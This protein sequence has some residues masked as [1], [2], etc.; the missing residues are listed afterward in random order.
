MA[1][2]VVR[3]L[4]LSS[5]TFPPFRVD[6]TV[7]FGRELAA[8]GFGV[9]WILQ[10]ATPC[11]HAF[12]APW[13]GGSVWVGPTDRGESRLNRLRK[14][15]LG[16]LHDLSVMKRARPGCYDVVQV[17]DKV[18]AAFPALWAARRSGAAFIY[19]LSFPHPEAS[20]YL[21]RIGAAR[22]RLLYR[23]RGWVQ[24]RL[25]YRIILPRADHVFVQ[26][27]QMKRDL[28]SYGLDASK[29]TPVPMG[30]EMQDFAEVRSAPRTNADVAPTIGYLGTLAGERRID[31]LVRCLPLVLKHKP[32]A[33]LLLVGGGDRPADVEN[34]TAE[35][36]RLGVLD[37][38]E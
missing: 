26:S 23:I 36:R 38:L 18:L 29:M 11:E 15:W 4:V 20:S 22:Y 8:R 33:R 35:A 28:V 7:L 21:A 24:F 3:M 27:E 25:L 12:A 2:P 13:G 1:D 6:V 14:H 9:D 19:W 34:I 37:K 17:K 32:G 31:F 30:V 10:S 5:D 16:V